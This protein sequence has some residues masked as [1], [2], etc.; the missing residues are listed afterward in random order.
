MKETFANI[1]VYNGLAWWLFRQAPVSSIGSLLELGPKLVREDY[2][3]AVVESERVVLG[4]FDRSNGVKE[5]L[6]H[7]EP[8]LL[9]P[10]SI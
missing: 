8:L 2:I 7:F 1:Y 10:V 3:S 9:S 5:T 4:R 6:P